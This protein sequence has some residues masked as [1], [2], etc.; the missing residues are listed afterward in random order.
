MPTNY[1]ELPDNPPDYDFIIDEDVND[2]EARIG[3]GSNFEQ[4][5]IDEDE[6]YSNSN[7]TSRIGSP[8]EMFTRATDAT[9]RFA[10]NFN[11][12]IFKPITLA[13]DPVYEFYRFL[14]GKFESYISKLGN[15]LIVKR[16][17]YIFM[18]AIVVYF[19]TMSGLYQENKG[20]YYGDFFDNSKLQE[21]I[22]NNI[23]AKRLQENLE[24]LS[25]MPHLAG[26]TGDLVLSRYLEQVMD[27]TPMQLESKQVFN[28]FVN[29]PSLNSYI[30]LIDTSDSD[31]ILFEAKLFEE[32]NR[33]THLKNSESDTGVGAGGVE[34]A[35][36]ESHREN[37]ENLG[38]LLTS[39]S[40]GKINEQTTDKQQNSKRD[41]DDKDKEAKKTPEIDDIAFNPGSKAGKVR[42]KLIYANFGLANDFQI[43]KNSGIKIEGSILM[44]KYHSSAPGLE[45]SESDKIQMAYENKV[46]GIIFISDPESKNELYKF[47]D[48][49]SIEKQSVGS[50]VFESGN[51]INPGFGV[52]DKI[53]NNFEVNKLWDSSKATPKIPSI[54]ISMNDAIKL[55]DSIKG[56]GKKIDKWDMKFP[57]NENKYEIWTGDNNDDDDYNGKIIEL[58]NEVQDIMNKEMWNVIGK[59]EGTEQSNLGII[60]GAQ[61]DSSSCEGSIMPNSGTAVLIE[62]MTVLSLMVHKLKWRPLR[63]IQFVSFDGG[64]YN[65]AG[66]SFLV[67]QREREFRRHCYAYIDLSDSISGIEELEINADPLL[68]SATEEV[69]K[70]VEDPTSNQTLFDYNWNGKNKKKF[71]YK[72]NQNKNSLPFIEHVAVPS[73]EIKFKNSKQKGGG[74]PINSCSD[75]FKNFQDNNIDPDMK[76]HKVLSEVIMRLALQLVQKPII[77]FDIV[78][79]VS[80]INEY[81]KD[82][83]QYS[84]DRINELKGGDFKLDFNRLETSLIKLK[85]IGREHIA[86]IETWSDI[87][88][89]GS[90]IEP[91]LLSVN[92]WDWNA[93][94]SLVEKSLLAMSGTL[95][96]PWNRNVLFGRQLKFPLRFDDNG[97]LKDNYQYTTFPGVRDAL[98]R[99]DWANAQSQLDMVT[100]L[101]D[102]CIKY[103]MI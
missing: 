12:T 101:L 73:I 20:S 42:G 100:D 68:W 75:N 10:K 99:G 61:R 14:N 30:R 83:K 48:M 8:R 57:S 90:G 31:K 84:F 49:S 85:S 39:D 96:R 2:E 77:P 13:L 102:Q 59:I 64:D 16:L 29:Y 38:N 36:T 27:A 15:P 19:V 17:F 67:R 69:L 91:N 40:N 26:T 22:H 25:S 98:E 86:F 89:A 97:E 70:Q 18:M 47:V 35:E 58:N 82:L 46:N 24:Y 95:D 23:D 65:L 53:P 56:K 51:I 37:N 54:P 6:L 50:T 94:I 93:K 63:T 66:S 60:I 28:S 71:Q 55:L 21:F 44:M 45:I 72:T 62:L 78:G 41:D 52:L 11:L 7:H 34:G 43:L 87:V 76:Y 74:Y 4:F 5:D 32:D 79:F 3:R 33:E 9:R 81:S 103:F 92:R 80:G 88:N 1:E